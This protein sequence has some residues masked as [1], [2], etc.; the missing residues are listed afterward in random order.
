M[1]LKPC[2]LLVEDEPSIVG[3]LQCMLSTYDFAPVWCS[4][5]EEILRQFEGELP[6]LMMLDV[7]LT[8]LHSLGL[9]R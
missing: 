4:I 6:V 1:S 9:F 2:V 3:T 8:D 5:A 7:G